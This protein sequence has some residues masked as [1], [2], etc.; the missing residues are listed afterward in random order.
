LA[1][2]A[3]A[4][5]TKVPSTSMQAAAG[6]FGEASSIAS[7]QSSSDPLQISAAGVGPSQTGPL[8]RQAVTPAHRPWT[9]SLTQATAAT[10]SVVPSQSSSAPLQTSAAGVRA[11]QAV[12]PSGPQ[13]RVPPQV[14]ASDNALQDV[15]SPRSA[16]EARHSQVPASGRQSSLVAPSR[17]VTASQV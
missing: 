6:Q 10:S 9:F 3:A 13:V 15:T 11:E 8:S 7:S 2:V 5:A 1:Q 4:V 17:V 16:H 14:P 12:R